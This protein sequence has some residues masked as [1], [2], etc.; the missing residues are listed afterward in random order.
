M[1]WCDFL[2][3]VGVRYV[4]LWCSLMKIQAIVCENARNRIGKLRFNETFEYAVSIYNNYKRKRNITCTTPLLA[5]RKRDVA[6][7]NTPTNEIFIYFLEIYKCLFQTRSLFWSLGLLLPV[8]WPAGPFSMYIK[9]HQFQEEPLSKASIMEA[10]VTPTE[11]L[12]ENVKQ[13]CT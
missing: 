2:Q 9:A 12:Q 5:H 10:F 3:K 8:L 6:N 11:A 7:K 4:K 13:N 1:N